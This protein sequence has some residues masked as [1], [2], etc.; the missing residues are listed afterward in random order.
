[1]ATLTEEALVTARRFIDA[2]NDRDLDALR[3][4]TDEDAEFRRMDGGA[5][6][7]HDGLRALLGAAGELDLRIV[8]FGGGA[9]E[10]ED[11][12]TTR[13]TLPVRELIG[14]DDI[15]RTAV[16]EVHDGRVVAFAVRP[17]GDE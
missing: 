15:E 8:P 2:F 7:G 17:Y 13:V 12:D 4:L 5:L 1:M 16:F 6:T 11:D 10:P 9:V 3:E 14:P